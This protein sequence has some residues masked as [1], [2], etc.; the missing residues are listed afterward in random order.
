MIRNMKDEGISNR[1]MAEE[2]GISTYT[3]RKLLKASS[4]NEHPHRQITSKLDPY[5]D[6]KRDII[7]K[8]NLMMMP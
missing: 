2:L 3:V 1:E 4:I 7:D 5:R 6:R 8:H